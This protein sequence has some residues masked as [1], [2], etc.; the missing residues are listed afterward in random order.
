MYTRFLI[1]FFLL[2]FNVAANGYQPFIETNVKTAK[3]LFTGTI[4][5]E[6]ENNKLFAYFGIPYAQPPVDT[7]RWKAPR[8]IVMQEKVK[9]ATK[10]PNRC[11]QLAGTIDSIEEGFTVGEIIGSED[12]LYLNLWRPKGKKNNLPVI[13]YIPVSYTNLTLPTIYSV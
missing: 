1:I 13:V 8:N 11:P 7:L 3:T 12:C 9:S 10:R 2:S 4:L 5:K 6:K